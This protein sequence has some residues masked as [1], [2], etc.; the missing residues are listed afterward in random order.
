MDEEDRFR[1]DL[2]RIGEEILASRVGA[3]G[4][5]LPMAEKGNGGSSRRAK[6]DEFP[7]L[8]VRTRPAGE[9]GSA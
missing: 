5:A 9:E 7:C 1:A 6:I 3:E 8:A 2:D 4:K